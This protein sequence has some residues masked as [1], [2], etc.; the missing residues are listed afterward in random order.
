M[1]SPIADLISEINTLVAA[2]NKLAAAE[3]QLSGGMNNTRLNGSTKSEWVGDQARNNLGSG[4]TQQNGWGGSNLLGAAALAGAYGAF[5]TRLNMRNVQVSSHAVDTIKT[6]FGDRISKPINFMAEKVKFDFGMAQ[7]QNPATRPKGL[8]AEAYWVMKQGYTSGRGQAFASP[9]PNDQFYQRSTSERWRQSVGKMLGAPDVYSMM[10]ETPNFASNALYQ[11]AQLAGKWSTTRTASYLSINARLMTRQTGRWSG[12]GG[13][14]SK[15]MV[16]TSRFVAEHGGQLALSALY[17]GA[18]GAKASIDQAYG[19]ISWDP[20]QPV[21]RPTNPWGSALGGTL[22][23]AAQ[24]G[25]ASAAYTQIAAAAAGSKTVG[26]VLLNLGRRSPHALVIFAAAHAS[27]KY[28][29]GEFKIEFEETKEGLREIGAW[30]ESGYDPA[31]KFSYMKLGVKGKA[32]DI[33]SEIFR[34]AEQEGSKA[35]GFGT[36]GA[37]GKVRELASLVSFGW[38]RDKN[39]LVREATAELAGRIK[40]ATDNQAQAMEFASRKNFRKFSS[41]LAQANAEMKD[42]ANP[43]W[44]NPKKLY[45]NMQAARLAARNYGSGLFTRGRQRVGD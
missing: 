18:Q 28:L 31:K 12:N 13:W 44:K 6:M 21:Y 37:T 33:E 34:R 41:K 24:I 19:P 20:S 40:R 30:R 36:E 39:E 45:Q 3:K 22:Q 25:A 23:T 29:S 10:K 8:M 5:G 4:H 1:P 9:Q 11:G 2:I 32:Y 43:A 27:Y 42:L 15:A 17:H 7:A 35:Y 16:G 14:T 26:S 38:I